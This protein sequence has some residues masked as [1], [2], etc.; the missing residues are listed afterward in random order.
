[1]SNK[2]A[3]PQNKLKISEL[4]LRNQDGYFNAMTQGNTLHVIGVGATGSFAVASLAR[5][6]LQNI[7][8][9]DGDIIESKNIQNQ[10][11]SISDIGRLKV[12]AIAERVNHDVGSEVVIPHNTM[13][14]SMDDLDLDGKEHTVLLLT[15]SVDSRLNI[16]EFL[17]DDGELDE[18]IETRLAVGH[19][20][21]HVFDPVLDEDGYYEQWKQGIQAVADQP[22]DPEHMELT[23]CGS[24]LAVGHVASMLGSWV[25]E[26]YLQCRRETRLDNRL[27]L[28]LR[29]N[30]LI[31][32]EPK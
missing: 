22:D 9:Y 21:L 14:E 17:E 11:Y 28:E 24:P 8:V 16:A 29:A 23:P 5:L 1:M 2:S 27:F 20:E 32:E 3:V 30:M 18:I 19:I 25:A 10:N 4:D 12:D 13:V 31:A 15:D 7:H 26:R 6:G